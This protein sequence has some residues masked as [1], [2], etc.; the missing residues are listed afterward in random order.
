MKTLMIA[1]VLVMLM[2]VA[3]MAGGQLDEGSCI[4]KNQRNRAAAAR[5]AESKR[6]IAEA[7]ET[8][9]GGLRRSTDSN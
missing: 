8:T 2:P 1:T 7:V 9:T 4:E 3:S 5:E 6:D